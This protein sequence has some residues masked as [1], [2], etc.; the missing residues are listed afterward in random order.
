MYQ[1]TVNSL[2][3]IN[4]EIYREVIEEP[5]NPIHYKVY[6]YSVYIPVAINTG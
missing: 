5:I 2:S 3:K 1:N 6:I 4:R